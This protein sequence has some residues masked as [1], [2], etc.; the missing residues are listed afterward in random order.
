MQKSYM[1]CNNTIIQETFVLNNAGYPRH[2]TSLAD[3]LQKY[4]YV[5]TKCKFEIANNHDSRT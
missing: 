1:K 3:A 2:V 5:A 4:K